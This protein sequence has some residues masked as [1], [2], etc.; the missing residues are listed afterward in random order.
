MRI[1][2]YSQAGHSPV[3]GVCVSDGRVVDLSKAALSLGV[4]LPLMGTLQDVVRA[5]SSLWE[6]IGGLIVQIE[7][8]TDPVAGMAEIADVD[9]HFPFRPRSNIVK[10]GGNARDLNGSPNPDAV[11]KLRYHT[12]APT[13]SADPG[14]IVTWRESLT[15][16]VYAEP[17]L[18]IVMGASLYFATP[19][20][21]REAVFGYSVSTDF[22]AWDLMQKHGQWPKPTSLDGFFPWG[23][24]IVTADEVPDPDALDIRLELN[25]ETVVA[26]STSDVLLP[27]G[28]M[29]AEVSSG[30]RIEAGD[31]FLLGTPEAVGFGRS[32]ARWCQDG[33]VIVSS[34]N[35]IGEISTQVR[36]DVT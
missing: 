3:V 4:D 2:T 18:V 27:I 31:V 32:P 7:A 15:A 9:L 26:G 17:Q 13:A 30:I 28:E 24:Y 12:K 33:D 19:D 5:G 10:A 36:I 1:C 8:T 34:I 16:Q 35:G 21:A 29:L 23:P 25:G 6:A 14:S 22:R 11:S 20:A